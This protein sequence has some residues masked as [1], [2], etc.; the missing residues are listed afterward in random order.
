MITISKKPFIENSL[1]VK[2]REETFVN[3]I[4]TKIW[5]EIPSSDN[6]YI[7]Q[8]AL[9]HG[10]NLLDLI[11][12]RSYIDVI[13]LLFKGEL[14]SSKQHELLEKLMIG[15]CNPGPR[16]DATRAAMVT[17]S[18]KSEVTHIL[19]ISLSVMGGSYL[20]ATE[21]QNAMRFLKAHINQNPSEAATQLINNDTPSSSLNEGEIV[22]GFGRIYDG[23][24]HLTHKVADKLQQIDSNN[25]FLYWGSQFSTTLNQS[26]HGWLFTGLAA[27]TFLDLNLDSRTGAALFQLISAPGLLAHGLEKSLSPV[28]DMPFINQQNYFIDDSENNHE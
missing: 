3:H 2:K 22:P 8:D 5:K 20:G 7:T 4:P 12:K 1:N 15:L 17:G 19:P 18:G 11:K 10:Y 9:C 16:H 13:Y 24:D 21:V 28:T 6:P 23:V 25:Q 14:P 27:A 26:G